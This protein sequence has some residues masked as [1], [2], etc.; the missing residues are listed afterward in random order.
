MKWELRELEKIPVQPT[1][2]NM[3]ISQ[4]STHRGQR[5]KQSIYSGFA[6]SQTDKQLDWL[7]KRTSVH[8]PPRSRSRATLLGLDAE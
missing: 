6:F 2:G 1:F 3:E 5:G 7:D 4:M 8:F